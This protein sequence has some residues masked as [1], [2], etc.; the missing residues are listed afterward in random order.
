MAKEDDLRR[1]LAGEKNLRLADLAGASLIE[2][3][4][5]HANLTR[6][7]LAGANLLEADLRGP[8]LIEANLN[9]TNLRGANL[10]RAN[11]RGAHLVEADLRGANLSEASLWGADL[12]RA[13]L[14]RANLSGANLTRARL[15]GADLTEAYL[16]HSNLSEST[17]NGADLTK[18]DLSEASLWGARLVEARLQNADLS[19]ADLNRAQMENT[20]LSGAVFSLTVF[21]GQVCR[22]LHLDEIVHDGPC[23]IE[24]QYLLALV[25]NGVPERFLKGIGIP[26]IMLNHLISTAEHWSTIDFSTCFI[27]YGREDSIFALRL[28]DELQRRGVRV[29]LVEK[30]LIVGDDLYDPIDRRARV[31]DKLIVCCS[32]AALS[33]EWMNQEIEIA[34]RMEEDIEAEHGYPVRN[35]YAVTLDDGLF[36]GCTAQTAPFVKSRHAASFVDWDHDETKFMTGCDTLLTRL[37]ADT[38]Q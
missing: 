19:G 4:L 34:T 29:W 17:L 35:L 33:S 11:L 15:Q 23:P 36:E 38:R 26:D 8:V 16:P 9:K 18:A 6:A 5:T 12:T 32:K 13:N 21:G 30:N 22:A 3:D 27:A 31:R 10:T 24:P 1:A 20:N 37:R 28:H 14:T 7:N 25:H 2:A